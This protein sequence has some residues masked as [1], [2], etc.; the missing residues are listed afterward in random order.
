MDFNNKFNERELNKKNILIILGI[1]L[2][3]GVLVFSYF[4]FQKPEEVVEP[5]I[6]TP[7]IIEEVIEE[8]EELVEVPQEDTFWVLKA[9]VFAIRDLSTKIEYDIKVGVNENMIDSR[10]VANSKTS[11]IDLNKKV[12]INPSSIL[13][14][15]EVVIYG[16]GNYN[17]GNLTASL[18]ALGSDTSYRYGELKGIIGDLEQGYEYTLSNIPDKLKISTDCKIYDSA[19]GYEVTSMDLIKVGDRVL[20]KYDPNFDI[21]PYGN[22]YTCTEVIVIVTNE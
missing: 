3:L 7:N 17:V 18:V 2:L 5:N 11:F 16:V 22:L 21:M 12:L 8:D 6:E 19:S 1:I 4:Y 13:V 15:S 10:A 20:F 9:N 14:G